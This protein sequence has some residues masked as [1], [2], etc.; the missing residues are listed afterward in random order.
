MITPS[1]VH[2]RVE[3]EAQETLGDDVRAVQIHLDHPRPPVP[4]FLRARAVH[5]LDLHLCQ[6]IANLC[7]RTNSTLD[8][9]LLAAFETLL[10]RY[11]DQ[12]DFIVGALSSDSIRWLDGRSPETV[13]KPVPLYANLVGDPSFVVY[14]DRLSQSIREMATC[15]DYP[16]VKIQR[17]GKIQQTTNSRIMFVPVG[18][19][20]LISAEPITKHHLEDGAEYINHCDLV[21]LLTPTAESLTVTCQYDTE[22]FEGN[23]IH[24][25]LNHYET[26]LEGIVAHP[27]AKLSQLPLLTESEREQLISEWN[28]TKTDYPNDKCIHQLFEEQ[29]EKTPDA[30]AL[31]FEDQQISYRE[32]NQRANQLAHYLQRHGVG[33]EVLVGICVERSIEMIVGLLAIL[34]AGGAYLPLDPDYPKERLDF[35]LQDAQ[36]KVLLSQ[37]QFFF[38]VNHS[39]VV[40]LDTDWH[41]IAIESTHNLQCH[42]TAENLAYVVYTSGSSGI[43]KGTEVPHRGVSRLLFGTTYAQLDSSQTLLQLAPISF[44]A[45]TFEIWGALLHGGKCALSTGKLTDPRELGD[46]LRKRQ[47]NTLWLTAAMFNSVID[48]EPQAL[49]AIKQLLI[50]GEALSL[51]HVNKALQHLP[52]T[53]IINGYGPTESTTFTCCY[54]IP[55][56]L[57]DDLPSVPIG[58]PIG[59]TQ[60]Y[61]LDA[62]LNPVPIGVAGELHI[63]GDG[64]ARGYL[65]RPQLTAEKFIA[66]PFSNEPGARLYKTG[67]LARYLADGNIEFLGRIDNQVKIRGYRIEL[68]E[69]EVV[70]ARH[71]HI[72]Q[73]VVLAREDTPGNHRLVAYSVATATCQPSAPA[74][75]TFLERKLPDFM[76][77]STFVFLDSLPLTPNGKLDR[78]AL[79]APDHSRSALDDAFAAPATPVETLLANIWAEVLKLDKIGLHD[80]FFRLGGHSL[81]ATQ[82][83]ARIRKSFSIDVALR[84]IFESPTIAALAQHVQSHCFTKKVPHQ[85]SI[86]RIVRDN[87]KA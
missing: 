63:G 25:L 69:I 55:R 28:D 70:L 2:P 77:P 21:F 80:N 87:F 72:Q 81:L 40:C 6:R 62:H 35:M 38:S 19:P 45:A 41:R 66:N 60:I 26:L 54:A 76:V 82:V 10:L 22:L 59:N 86:S 32:L 67:D 48:Q 16:L 37:Q 64:L 52:N 43:P 17:E 58:R 14:L 36:A 27:E 3:L 15:R 42:V 7:A 75:R 30:I 23:T 9:C 73:T 31:V 50:G 49:G 85:Q 84:D 74:L 71:P 47:V 83:I 53:R 51:P 44:D 78:K 24:R 33:P 29:D 11:T 46:V 68:G 56:Q 5:H 12:D 79:P 39:R 1:Y 61:L 20:T 57:N 65:N 34:K 18:M 4:A 13:T 8:V